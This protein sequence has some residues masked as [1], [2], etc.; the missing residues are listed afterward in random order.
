MA[1]R[2]PLVFDTVANK[3]KELPTGDNLNMSSSSINDAI[4]INASGIVSA[5][6]VNT[7][8]LNIAGTPIGEVAK[9]NSYTDLSNLPTLFDGD[10]NSLTNKPSA[11]V[12]AWA[13]ITGKPVIASSLSQLVNDTNF[14][15]NAQVTI[16]STQVAGLAAVAT[17]G[18]YLDLTDAAQLISRAEIAGGTLTIDVNNTGDLEG[19][20]FSTD[21]GT[22][23]IDGVTKS[24]SLVNLDATGTITGNLTG[25]HTGTHIGDVYSQDGIK[26]VLFSGNTFEDDALFKGNVSGQLFSPDLSTMLVDQ[27]GNFFGDFKGS[28]FGDDSSVIVDAITNSVYAGTITASTKFVGNV[29]STATLTLTALN[30]ITLSPAGPVNVPN[31]STISLSATSTIA[32]GATDNLTLTSA[33]GNVVVQ[34]HISITNLKTLVAGAADY[35]AFQAAIAAL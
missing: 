24:A 29:E 7:V 23:L 16:Q 2:I 31:A 9:T 25:D 13:D 17:G 3:I 26:Q 21:G 28:L 27:D 10:Y 30:G 34:D 35:A 33:S 20:V 8:N 6:T 19:S 1:N 18:S 12:A 4:N 22:K 32:I 14:V 5:N 15:T 11:I